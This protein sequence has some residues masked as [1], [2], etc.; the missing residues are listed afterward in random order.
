MGEWIRAATVFVRCAYGW[1]VETKLDGPTFERQCENNRLGA[2]TIVSLLPNI[3]TCFGERIGSLF[4]IVT[5]RG[6]YSS[7]IPLRYQNT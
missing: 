7:C 3:T 5:V 4:G 1:L 6:R 2:D